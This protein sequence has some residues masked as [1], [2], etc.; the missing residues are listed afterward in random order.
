MVEIGDNE[1]DSL[2]LTKLIYTEAVISETMRL[3]P[4]IP[5]VGRYCDDDIDLGNLT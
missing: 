4:A 2:H 1:I 3:L 5:G